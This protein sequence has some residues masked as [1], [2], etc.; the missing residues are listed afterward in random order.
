VFIA[1]FTY[2]LVSYIY[3]S[4]AAVLA[5]EDAEGAHAEAVASRAVGFARQRQGIQP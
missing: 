5:L 2:L 3:R 1:A 4:Q